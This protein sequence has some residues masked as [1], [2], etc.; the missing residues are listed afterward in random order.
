MPLAMTNFGKVIATRKNDD[1]PTSTFVSRL[2]AARMPKAIE[3]GTEMIDENSARRNVLR[4]CLMAVCD[5][6]ADITLSQSFPYAVRDA[7]VS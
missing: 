2:T 5:V 3:S 1:S 6:K 4:N 7:A